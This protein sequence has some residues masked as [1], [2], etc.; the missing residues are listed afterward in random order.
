MGLRE[1]ALAAAEAAQ[2]QRQTVA[3]SVLAARLTPAEVSGLTVETTTSDLV[4]FTDG[5]LRLAVRDKSE[6]QAVFLVEPDDA[7]GWTRL[8]DVPN[9]PALGSI[10]ANDSEPA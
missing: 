6:P 7:G 4:I 8:G 10:L 3:R 2:E 1:D 9:L 5:T